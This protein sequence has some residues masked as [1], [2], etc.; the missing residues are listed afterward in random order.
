MNE[1]QQK[2][3][4]GFLT[5]APASTAVPLQTDTRSNRETNRVD[6][7]PQGQEVTLLQPFTQ[8]SQDS[9]I[10]ARAWCLESGTGHQ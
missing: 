8:C 4:L 3:S 7:H 2:E 5:K 1:R 6:P 9:K 10:T